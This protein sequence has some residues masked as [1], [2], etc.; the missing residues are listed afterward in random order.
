[1]FLSLSL[2]EGEMEGGGGGGLR[3]VPQLPSRQRKVGD[4]IL[5]DSKAQDEARIPGRTGSECPG[6]GC[7]LCP[8]SHSQGAVRPL[9]HS[10]WLMEP[11]PRAEIQCQGPTQKWSIS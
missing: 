11:L 5:K 6:T 3:K 2:V 4:S 1:M 7:A 10:P 9:G 8:L